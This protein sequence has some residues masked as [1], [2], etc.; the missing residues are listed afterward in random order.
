MASGTVL[1][2]AAILG[3][4]HP[5][6]AKMRA[7]KRSVDDGTRTG[8]ERSVIQLALVAFHRL[9]GGE[10]EIRVGISRGIGRLLSER[11]R[12]RR[13]VDH[14]R[15]RGGAPVPGRVDRMDDEGVRANS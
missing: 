14:P 3:C 9:V 15:V 4:L 8:H 12:W 2:A 7:G 1:D 5:F 10:A 6:R 13:R 11:D